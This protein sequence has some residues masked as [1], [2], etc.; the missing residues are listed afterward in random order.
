MSKTEL[1]KSFD[2][3]YS[4]MRNSRKPY[5]CEYCGMQFTST[6]SKNKHRNRQHDAE[7][8]EKRY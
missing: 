6:T 8:W 1:K 5:P 4:S 2:M 7:M 3:N